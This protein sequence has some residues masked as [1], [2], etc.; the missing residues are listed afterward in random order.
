MPTSNSQHIVIVGAGPG[1]LAAS[2][3]LAKAGVNVTVVERSSKVGGRTKV[4]ERDGFKFDLGPTFFHYTEVIEE[5]FQA[6]GKDAHK[7]LKLNQLDLNYRLIFG[8]GGELD[9]TSDLDVMRDRIA[10]LSGE[11][12]ANAFVRYV[13]DNR[14]KLH[15]AKACLQEPWNGPRDIFSKR[16][17]RAATVLRPTRSV[18]SDLM[19][20]FDD[21]RLMLAMSFQTKYLGMSP[22]NCPSLFTILAFLEYEY[23]IFH[24]TGGL[25]SVPVRMAEIAKEMGV[26][27]RLGEAVEEVIMDGKTAVGVRTEKGTL[28]ADRVIVNADFAN[29]MTSIVPNKA[30]K[31]WTDKKLESKKYL[32]RHSCSTL[33]LTEP[34]TCHITKSTLPRTTSKIWKTSKSITVF[35]GTIHRSMSRTLVS[36][37]LV[38]LQKVAQRYTSLFLFLIKLKTSTG[39]KNRA[40]SESEFSIKSRPNS[41][42]KTSVTT[43]SLK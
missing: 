31:R 5:I 17:M 8:Q 12:D 29:A 7:E 10:V 15:R 26:Q 20:L 40:N 41:V 19:R 32:V 33:V 23:G 4:I 13:E 25:G 21:D 34:M 27:F 39:Q 30:R 14:K 35:L 6:I 42:T 28:M 1:G 3:L 18:A 43:S 37:T 24:P 9:C 22:F 11:K 38:S 16:V 36:P 2:L